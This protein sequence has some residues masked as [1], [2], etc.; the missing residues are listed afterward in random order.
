LPSAASELACTIRLQHCRKYQLE[1]RL[2]DRIVNRAG[3]TVG[4][5]EAVMLAIV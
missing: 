2:P 1:M 5:R 3:V 4:T